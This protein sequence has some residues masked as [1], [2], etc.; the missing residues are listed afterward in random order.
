MSNVVEFEVRTAIERQAREWLIR[1]DSDESLS[2]AEEASLQE[3]LDHSPAHKQ[4]LARIARFWGRANVLTELAVPLRQARRAE[5]SPPAGDLWRR[6]RQPHLA[7]IAAGLT[8]LS[9][10]LIVWR[11]QM[12][13]PVANGIYAT[14]IGE[15][16]AIDL[17]DG[18]S[19][20]L[21][22]DS[23]VQID[24]S[25]TR[26]RLR[27]L[28]GEALFSVARDA[29][30]PFEVHAG[31]GLVT[32]LGTSFSVHLKGR[33]VNVTV[34]EGLVELAVLRGQAPLIGVVE[35]AGALGPQRLG[36][37]RAGEAT[38]FD[39]VLAQ[40]QVQQ[41]PE[42]ELQRR[43]SWQEGY[44]VFSGEPLAEVVTEL[45]RYSPVTLEIVDP[46]LAQV[47]IGGRFRVGDLDAVLDVLHASFGIESTRIDDRYI[48]LHA[49]QP[50]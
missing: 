11:V 1:L 28:R 17:P 8:V 45:N 32:A 38:A 30:K 21:N 4:E 31:E 23:Q 49:A 34:S 16:E 47:A 22:T 33:Q 15:Q 13:A 7:A 20:Q 12:P 2:A 43:L 35:H 3:W 41:L 26:R 42:P 14:A 10:L 19:V 6:W 46:R 27:L 40:L 44:L 36:I 50:R 37:L 18:S 29:T 24:Y 39:P 48:R 25:A 9:A 5:S